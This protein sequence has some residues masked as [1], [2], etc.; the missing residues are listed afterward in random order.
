MVER[1]LKSTLSKNVTLIAGNPH[2][3]LAFQRQITR[4]FSRGKRRY[5]SLLGIWPGLRCVSVTGGFA[6]TVMGQLR[7]SAGDGVMIHEVFT[8]AE[9]MIAAQGPGALP[10]LHLLAGTGI[11]FEFLPLEDYDAKPLEEIGHKAVPVEKA[12]SGK[13][14]LI[15][16]TTPAGLVRHLPGNVVRFT[17]VH[18]PRILPPDGTGRPTT[19]PNSEKACSPARWLKPY[20]GSVAR[21]NGTCRFSMWLL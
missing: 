14:Y 16:L 17:S 9:A 15:V 21:I 2:W 8:T 7:E 19:K 4:T 12:Q 18:P 5:N 1:L 11:Y 3:L 20:P 13:D 6:M 10:G